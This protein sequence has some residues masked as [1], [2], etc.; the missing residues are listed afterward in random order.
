VSQVVTDHAGTVWHM[1]DDV[2]PP[3]APISFTVKHDRDGPSG[4]RYTLYPV[5]VA[6]EPDRN[7]KER[8][9]LTIDNWQV[10][11]GGSDKRQRK[12]SAEA[13]TAL[14]TIANVINQL[15][16]RAPAGNKNYPTKGVRICT[17]DEAFNA[18]DK[19]GNIRGERPN[20]IFKRRLAALKNAGRIG[21]WDNNLWIVDPS[22]DARA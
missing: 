6:L 13:A 22:Q 18:L 3:P 11:S 10:S 20:D 17:I 19:A 4:H 8:T 15:E 1:D 7:G 14:Q 12:L 2:Q 5:S 21:E 9:T 16:R